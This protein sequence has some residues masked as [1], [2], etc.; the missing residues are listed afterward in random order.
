MVE[1]E[2]VKALAWEINRRERAYLVGMTAQELKEEI[3][4]CQKH[5]NEFAREEEKAY[6]LELEY[7][8][9]IGVKV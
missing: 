8:A 3:A 2:T 6:K 5:T 9:N 1:S 4:E 7:L